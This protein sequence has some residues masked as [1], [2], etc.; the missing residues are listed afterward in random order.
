MEHQDG[1]GHAVDADD[2]LVYDVRCWHC[3]NKTAQPPPA[4][5]GPLPEWLEDK[6]DRVAGQRPEA[7]RP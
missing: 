3:R 4:T 7:K 5:I 6:L 1:H 2:N